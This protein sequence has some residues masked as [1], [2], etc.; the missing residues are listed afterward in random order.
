MQHEKVF[1]DPSPDGRNPH[2]GTRPTDS[3]IA[4]MIAANN[5][6]FPLNKV[7]VSNENEGNFRRLHRK[8]GAAY[9]KHNRSCRGLNFLI[10][11]PPGQ[12]KSFLV[13]HFA[14][15]IG[16][17][18]VEVQSGTLKNTFQL[19]Q[20]ISKQCEVCG[21]P[22][23]SYKTTKADFRFPP[24]IVFFDEVHE[25]SL[26]LQRGGLLNAME[27]S[28]GYMQVITPGIQG[29]SFCVDAKDVCWIGATTDPA[30]LFDAFRSR[31]LDIIEWLPAGRKELPKIIKAG[32]DRKVEEGVLPYSPPLMI[33]AMI[34]KYQTVPRLAI[35]GFGND[36][37]LQKQAYPHDTWEQACEIVA[38][39]LSIDQWG[40]SKKELILLEHLG[41]R[42]IAKSRLG[43]VL[44]CRNKTV[45]DL[46][47][48][49]LMQYL[50]GGPFVVII[51]GR[52][53]CISRAGL[54]ELDKRNIKHSGEKIT[55]EYFESKR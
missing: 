35:H 27:P 30:D 26:D 23:V 46:V 2:L 4:V 33:C 54:R 10:T 11:S 8:V 12:G 13:R 25:V 18:Y 55:A 42:P 50:N 37:V 48:P 53:V 19:F 9:R 1:F 17:P 22:V 41:Q 36:V 24:C 47:L 43:N 52:G 32:L 31:F 34:T 20:L 5:Q 39:D 29:E 45:E 16:I 7:I 6:S 49:N 28:D 40:L 15:S 51:T 3:E 44:N 14:E 38:K 21:V